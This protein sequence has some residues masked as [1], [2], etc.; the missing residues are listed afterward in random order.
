MDSQLPLGESSARRSPLSPPVSGAVLPMVVIIPSLRMARP[1]ASVPSTEPP[2]ESS[3][4]TAP[5]T[6]GSWA[7]VSKSRGVSAVI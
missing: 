2:S 7:K 4:S 5:R 1:S 6:L 3:T